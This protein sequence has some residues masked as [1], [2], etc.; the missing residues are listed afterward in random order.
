MPSAEAPRECKDGRHTFPSNFIVPDKTAINLPEMA[1]AAIEREG[2]KTY[3][4]IFFRSEKCWNAA[5]KTFRK[6]TQ[7]MP[8]GLGFFLLFL[9]M[10][11][12]QKKMEYV[13]QKFNELQTDV[14]ILHTCVIA[15][16]KEKKRNKTRII[17][18]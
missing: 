11:G 1:R 14:L 15:G 13:P 8:G 6:K 2:E 7:G 12:Y 18:S 17:K 9:L 5:I 16:G 4:L 3:Q 10:L